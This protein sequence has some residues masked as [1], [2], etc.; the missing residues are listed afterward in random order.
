MAPVTI[1]Q[2]TIDL[3]PSTAE[4]TY[5]PADASQSNY[6]LIQCEFV[7]GLDRLNTEQSNALRKVQVDV[8]GYV[9][10]GTYLCRYT[11]SDLGK[12]EQLPFIKHA[13]VYHV[14]FKIHPHLVETSGVSTVNK[15]TTE[16]TS[17]GMKLSL[18]SSCCCCLRS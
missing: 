2:N 15:A 10:S 7:G 13:V 17:Q 1:N 8:Q 14:G 12:I 6:V 4:P 9:G 16:D 5:F 3:D 18:V 11:P